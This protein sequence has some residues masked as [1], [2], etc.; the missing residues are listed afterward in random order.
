MQSERPLNLLSVWIMVLIQTKIKEVNPP[1]PTKNLWALSWLSLSLLSFFV[2][3]SVV[4]V[5][6]IVAV[7]VIIIRQEV[8]I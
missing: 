6:A 2:G 4:V 3:F 1:P 8:S 5:F 7:I